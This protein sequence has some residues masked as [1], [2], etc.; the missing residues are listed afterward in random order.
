MIA[1][2]TLQCE[3]ILASEFMNPLEGYHLITPEDLSWRPANL[4]QIP[5]ADWLALKLRRKCHSSRNH[6]TNVENHIPELALVVVIGPSGC[7]KSSAEASSRLTNGY[8]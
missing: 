8:S 7:G 6:P 3:P 2:N 5:N 4:M 1:L